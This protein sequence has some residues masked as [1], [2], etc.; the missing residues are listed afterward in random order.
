MFWFY[1]KDRC[2]HAGVWRSNIQSFNRLN[3]CRVSLKLALRK[4]NADKERI[5]DI[6]GN[7]FLVDFFVFQY[8]SKLNLKNQ[9]HRSIFDIYN[10]LNINEKQIRGLK[11]GIPRPKDIDKDIDKEDY[12]YKVD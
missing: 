6:N 8:G 5:I 12:I 9:V 2:N 7:W 11:G 4:L 10:R 3:K 1:V